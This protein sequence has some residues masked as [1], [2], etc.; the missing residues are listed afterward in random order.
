V[1][2]LQKFARPASAVDGKAASSGFEDHRA[3]AAQ[4]TQV[5]VRAERPIDPTE[6]LA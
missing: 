3:F 4:L 5:A 6:R 1:Q 2:T